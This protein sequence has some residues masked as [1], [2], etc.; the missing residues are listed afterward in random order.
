MI[1]KQSKPIF[2]F[3]VLLKMLKRFLELW[4]QFER[5]TTILKRNVLTLWTQ[6]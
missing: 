4:K 3:L 6:V 2:N 5:I 1:S